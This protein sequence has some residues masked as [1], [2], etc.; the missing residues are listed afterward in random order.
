MLSNNYD[1]NHKILM[2]M[3]ITLNKKIMKIT[4]L[5]SI[6]GSFFFFSCKNDSVNDMY[7]DNNREVIIQDSIISG[8]EEVSPDSLDQTPTVDTTDYDVD[9]IVNS[10]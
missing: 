8:T 6:I 2:M 1:P 7:P 9:S 5:F 3:K 10:R 4:I